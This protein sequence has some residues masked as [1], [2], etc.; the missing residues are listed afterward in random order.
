MFE[1]EHFPAS[2]NAAL[3]IENVYNIYRW[4]FVPIL[5]YLLRDISMGERCSLERRVREV[6]TSIVVMSCSEGEPE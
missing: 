4:V 6:L 5:H 2:G 3:Y 1:C